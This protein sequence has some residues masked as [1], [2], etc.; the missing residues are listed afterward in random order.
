MLESTREFIR[1]LEEAE[2][3]YTVGEPTESGK[4]N[5][6]ISF[7]GDNMDTIR[8]ALLFDTD[9]ESAA[10]RVFNIVKI[11]SEKIAKMFITVNALNIKYRF[12][13]FCI[14]TNDNTVQMEMDVPF[15]AGSVG[16]VCL[17]MLMY[18]VSICDKAYPELMKAIWS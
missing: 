16:P 3:K 4:D 1:K 14:D 13:K 12:G 15:R 10:V 6:I 8:C 5:V 18:S 17:E 9:N 7:G 11:P 2:V